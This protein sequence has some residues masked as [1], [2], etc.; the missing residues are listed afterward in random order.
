MASMSPMIFL[1]SDQKLIQYNSKKL[2]H[3]DQRYEFV[4]AIRKVCRHVGAES[5]RTVHSGIFP[6]ASPL[7]CGQ[8]TQTNGW[9]MLWQEDVYWVMEAGCGSMVMEWTL[10]NGGGLQIIPALPR[11]EGKKR[12]SLKRGR[13][14]EEKKRWVG[15][16]WEREIK[17]WKIKKKKEKKEERARERIWFAG[18]ERKSVG[19]LFICWTFWLR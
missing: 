6:F 8:L 5:R 15:G 14:K 4:P 13:K 11:R 10:R 2:L 9:F 3:Q 12:K 1:R 18:T 16:R 19:V 7:F 17:R